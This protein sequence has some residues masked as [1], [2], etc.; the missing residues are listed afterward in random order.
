MKM[1]MMRMMR[2]DMM[3]MKMTMTMRCGIRQHPGRQVL[4]TSHVMTDLMPGAGAHS[5]GQVISDNRGWS[6]YPISGLTED[7]YFSV[8]L[9]D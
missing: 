2:S 3:K 5:P 4:T 8:E 9:E 1:R 7:Y 6:H